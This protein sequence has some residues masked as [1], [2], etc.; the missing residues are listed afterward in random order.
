MMQ[1]CTELVEQASSP[2]TLLLLLSRLTLDVGAS[3]VD[4]LMTLAD[5]MY[6]IDTI[7]AE[8][9]RSRSSAAS[10][11]LLTPVSRLSEEL[12][13]IAQR[14]MDGYV[15]AQGLAVSQM[16]RKS[17]ETRD[18]L[19]TIEPRHVRAVMKRL[20]EDV[21]RMDVQVS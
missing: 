7:S 13:S 15:R 19:N 6:L 8:A 18:W 17:V 5:E 1:R 20:V 4:Y 10:A 11:P 21:S 12:R 14:L 9:G 16:L 3:A 2:P